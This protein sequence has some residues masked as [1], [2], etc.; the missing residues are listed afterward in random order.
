MNIHIL[1]RRALCLAFS[2]IVFTSLAANAATLDDEPRIDPRD[3]TL[4]GDGP[5]VI[6][7]LDG[8][9]RVVSVSTEGAIIDTTYA[10]LPDD[11][12]LHVADHQ[13]RFPFDVK[14]HK[15]ERQPWHYEQPERV[16]VMSDPHGKLDCVISLLQANGVID[17]GYRWSFGTDHL[18]VIGDIFDRGWD[19]PQIF[20]LFYKLEAEAAEAGGQVSFLLGNHEPLVLG[21][22]MRYTKPK[23]KML[24][25]SIGIAYPQLFG[26]DTELGYWLGTRNTMQVIGRDLYVHAG[27]SRKFFE[28]HLSIPTVNEEMSRGLFYEKQARREFSILTR[29]LFGNDGPVWYRGLVRDEARYDPMSADSLRLCLSSYGADRV[30]VGHT[31]F[32]DI[33]IFYDG[34]VI[35]VNVDNEINRDARRGRAVLIE[36]GTLYVVGDEGKMRIIAGSE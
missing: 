4:T 31:I 10:A 34:L 24:A 16:F 19:V 8:G 21:N 20:W 6:Y 15:I 14:L 25:D 29:F 30:F 9:V 18:V 12:T 28:R 36:G 5:Y 32:D 33:S 17:D 26:P 3:T 2:L 22:D 23:Y 11:F 1:Y 35:D 13:G 7:Q 27:L